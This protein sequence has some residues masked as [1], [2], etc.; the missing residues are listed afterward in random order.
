MI[1][2]GAS[3]DHCAQ[4]MRLNYEF[5]DLCSI[6]DLFTTWQINFTPD[7]KIYFYH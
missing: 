7:I 2:L 1:L 6:E 4:I 3:R 5:V